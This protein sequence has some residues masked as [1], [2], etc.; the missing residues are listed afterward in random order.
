MAAEAPPLP[1]PGALLVKQGAE[2]VSE[3][4]R[5]LA[6]GSAWSFAEGGR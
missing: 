4:R 2:A 5:R 3:G 6:G 1:E